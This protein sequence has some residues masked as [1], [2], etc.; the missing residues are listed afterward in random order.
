MVMMLS[1]PYFID[2]TVLVESMTWRTKKRGNRA[3]RLLMMVI[4]F[5]IVGPHEELF[6]VL[7]DSIII[8]DY[9]R[10]RIKDFDGG[11]ELTVF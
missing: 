2:D 11:E 4:F 6:G 1:S 3:L 10:K 7:Y 8:G 9:F 5:C